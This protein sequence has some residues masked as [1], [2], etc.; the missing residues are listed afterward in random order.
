[1]TAANRAPLPARGRIRSALQRSVRRSTRPE[2]L[3]YQ[4]ISKYT[5]HFNGSLIVQAKIKENRND[6]TPL[7]KDDWSGHSTC[8]GRSWGNVNRSE[9]HTSELQSRFGI[10]YA[11]FCLKT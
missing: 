11:V 1:M 2:D 9:E 3:W 8:C 6:S 7:S 10:S 5:S 4:G